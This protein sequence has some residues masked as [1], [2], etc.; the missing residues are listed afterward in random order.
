MT[1]QEF[2]E[3]LCSIGLPEL[4]AASMASQASVGS[5]N[6][7]FESQRMAIYGF[8]FWDKTIEGQEFWSDLVGCLG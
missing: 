1:R 3:H 8:A 2:Y 7:K 5:K 6:M 4:I